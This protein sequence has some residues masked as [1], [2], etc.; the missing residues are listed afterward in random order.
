VDVIVLDGNQRPALAVVRSLGKRG[1]RIAVGEKAL[2][3]LSSSSR[4]CRL[5]FSYPSPYTSSQ[6]FIEKIREVAAQ[7]RGAVLFPMTDVTLSEVLENKTQ[8]AKY[9][10]IPFADYDKYIAASNKVSLF[11]LA[12]NL[13]IPMPKT[14]FSSDF[15]NTE[16]LVVE[17]KQL[18]FPLVLKSASS[19]IRTA[20]GWMNGGIRYAKGLNE[21]KEILD[22]EPFQSYPFLVQERIEGPGMG[23]FLLMHKGSVIARFAHERIREKPPSGGVSVLCQSISP[24]HEALNAAIRLLESLAWSGVAMVEFKRDLRDGIPKLIEVNARFWGSVQLAIAA[25]VDFPYLLY[26]LAMGKEIRSSNHYKVGIKSRWEL[27]DLDHLFILLKRKISDLSLPFNT[28]SRGA[29][30]KEFLW[31]FFRP[32]VR[33]EVFRSDDPRP[34][35]F[36]L[37]QYLRD[38]LP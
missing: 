33:N 19:R 31:D 3:S 25:G 23:I 8:L 21:S 24:P 36:E 13:N 37:K 14:V 17:F 6:D 9:V 30:L 7:S 26:C 22:S 10:E 27:G 29:V 16:E 34:F 4:Y 12:Q 11:K 18:G 2:P 38:I 1:I 20:H 35:L 5:G 32:S 28:S 15:R